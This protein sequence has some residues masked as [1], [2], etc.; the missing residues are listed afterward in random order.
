MSAGG[1]A[2]KEKVQPPP[3]S[4]I[5]TVFSIS[6]GETDEFDSDAE[7]LFATKAK[8]AEARKEA[9]QKA[10]LPKLQAAKERSMRRTHAAKK[11]ERRLLWR[12]SIPA[13]VS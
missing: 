12:K 5:P 4:P 3:S 8:E 1:K 9:E 6:G 11:M 2:R 7:E 10:M 13:K